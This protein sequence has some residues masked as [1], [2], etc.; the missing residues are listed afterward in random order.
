M[1]FEQHQHNK[2]HQR[3]ADVLTIRSAAEQLPHQAGQQK[4]QVV[5]QVRA[6]VGAQYDQRHCGGTND[7]R[8]HQHRHYFVRKRRQPPRHCA[9]HK[10]VGGQRITKRAQTGGRFGATAVMT[11][12]GKAT[13]CGC[14]QQQDGPSP[15]L[16]IWRRTGQ[17][18]ANQHAK[19]EFDQTGNAGSLEN[20]PNPFFQDLPI[21]L[22]I[23]AN[24]CLAVAVDTQV[25]SSAT[26]RFND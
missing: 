7:G 22:A 14:E 26:K 12:I 15:K 4:W 1:S 8:L 5:S 19:D 24:A 2:D 18:H 17:G 3:R 10:P 6:P 25:K 13:P 9:E 23:L 16:P 20:H 11:P 21:L